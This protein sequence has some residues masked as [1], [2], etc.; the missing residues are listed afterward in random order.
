M[1]NGGSTLVSFGYFF[2]LYRCLWIV[3][4]FIENGDN[5]EENLNTKCRLTFDLYQE[6]KKFNNSLDELYYCINQMELGN[7]LLDPLNF[8]TNPCAY[9]VHITNCFYLL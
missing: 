6:Y 2:E 9:R 1:S 4:R 8:D 5:N 7:S 3:S